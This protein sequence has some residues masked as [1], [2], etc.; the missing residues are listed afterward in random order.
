M[1][2]IPNDLSVEGIH[3]DFEGFR[4]LLKGGSNDSKIL[5]ISFDFYLSYR[6]T[7]ESYLSKI[8]CSLKDTDGGNLYTVLNSSYL[9]Y[10][11]ET[12]A[13]LFPEK[14]TITHYAIYTTDDCLDVLAYQDPVVEW[15]T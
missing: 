4:I 12:S 9:E 13:G 10:L 8:W 14:W 6:N 5:R 11:N 3:D 7:D 1:D 2:G 15:L